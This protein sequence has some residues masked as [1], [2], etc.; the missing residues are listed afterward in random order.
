MIK[1]LSILWIAFFIFDSVLWCMKIFGD[2]IEFSYIS[3]LSMS[4]VSYLEII[5]KTT[6]GFP[7]FLVK[8]V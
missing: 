7:L 1:I 5:A 3:F 2:K 8:I 4:L 6:N